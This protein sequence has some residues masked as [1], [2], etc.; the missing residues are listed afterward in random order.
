MLVLDS[1][2]ELKPKE[3]G[4]NRGVPPALDYSDQTGTLRVRSQAAYAFLARQE[5][6]R[7]AGG[8][9]T[10]MRA[11]LFVNL[12]AGLGLFAAILSG[13]SSHGSR[14]NGIARWIMYVGTYTQP[15]SKGIYC[16]IFDPAT[17]N[18]TPIELA[19][20]AE[21]PS[22][23][24]VHPTR[25]FLYAANETVTY[26]SEA[27]GSISAFAIESGTGR[28]TLLNKVSSKGPGP[29]HISVEATGKWLFAANYDGGSVAG[30][31]IRPDGSLS[32]A[33]TFIQHTGSSVNPERQASPHAHAV[34]TSRD[35][36]FL[37]VAD[38]GLDR[39][40][41]YRLDSGARGLIPENPSFVKLAPGSGPRHVA[42]TPDGRAA[43]VINEMLSTIT[44]FRYA[45]GSGAF[46]ELQTVST[47]PPG[48]TGSNSTA[49]IAVHPNGRFLY[50]SNRGHDSIAIFRIDEGKGTLTA[51]GHAST[52]GHTPRSFAIDPTGQYMLAANQ[53][54]SSIIVF[55]IDP[56]TGGLTPTGARLDVPLPVCIVLAAA[57]F[58]R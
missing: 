25:Q 46:H 49:E 34:T 18:V 4:G 33:S 5:I 56:Q 11:T 19:A 42:V 1:I 45:T 39:V 14:P 32:G 10:T 30:F 23:L 28:L 37:L 7:L 51:A 29:C 41:C 44:A 40:F 43:Y 2:N 35:N 15:P 47:L 24:A 3:R 12:Y 6:E 20:Q 13:V 38:L 54:S 53:D 36:R 17:G 57:G 48:F 27:A 31:P 22:F 16:C 8:R 52:L 58:S 21:N 50:G 9:D 55:R 26:Q